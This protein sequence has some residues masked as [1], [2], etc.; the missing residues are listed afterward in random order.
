MISFALLAAACTLPS[1]IKGHAPMFYLERVPPAERDSMISV[2]LC[3]SSPTTGL[4]SYSLTLGYDSTQMVAR[5][6]DVTGPG[7]Q[8]ANS[9]VAGTVRIAGAAP[10]GFRSGL[11]GTLVLKPK[12]GRNLGR[13]RLTL[14]EANSPK[15]ASILSGARVTGYP[16]SDQTLGVVSAPAKATAASAPRIDSLT[17]KSARFNDE[18]VMEIAIYGRGFA[19]RGNVVLFD[20]ASVEGVASERQG[21]VIRFL[22]P[23]YIPPHGQTQGRRVTPGRYEIR[24]KTPGGTSNSVGF[25]ARES[26]R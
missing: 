22:A 16:A 15:A 11:L 21:T 26:E 19:S 3:L 17:P 18:G 2:R 20:A 7:L 1:G 10:T 4:G 9:E 23:S 24:V 14:L 8:V 13:I 6:V 12:K 25:V 5:R